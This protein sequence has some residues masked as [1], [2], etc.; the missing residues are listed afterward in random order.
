MIYIKL[1]IC[2]RALYKHHIAQACTMPGFFSVDARE[3]IEWHVYSFKVLGAMFTRKNKVYERFIV[4]L[5]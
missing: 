5:W 3:V 1:S 4:S 2:I